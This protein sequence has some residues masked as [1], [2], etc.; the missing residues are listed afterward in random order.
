[1]FFIKFGKFS[2]AY[3]NFLNFLARG[4]TTFSVEQLLN[5]EKEVFSN[6]MFSVLYNEKLNVILLGQGC[7]Q[8]M[9]DKGR[10]I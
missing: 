10:F 4:K 5:R 8:T 1:M 2:L 3:L 7:F 9:C 6:N